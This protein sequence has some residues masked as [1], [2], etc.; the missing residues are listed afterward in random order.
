MYTYSPYNLVFKQ[1]RSTVPK[2]ALFAEVIQ[3][4]YKRDY[5]NEEKFDTITITS[6][7][8]FPRSDT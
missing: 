4:R 6:L 3:Y 1:S 5:L 2:K 7:V 8:Y